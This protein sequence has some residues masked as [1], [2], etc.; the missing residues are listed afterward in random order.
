MT[1]IGKTPHGRAAA[2]RR[3]RAGILPP[4]FGAQ[5]PISTTSVY[6]NVIL[7]GTIKSSSTDY[8]DAMSLTDSATALPQFTPQ[9]ADR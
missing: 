7:G 5:I 6:S 3:R 1:V 8:L 2:P 9:E 4:N